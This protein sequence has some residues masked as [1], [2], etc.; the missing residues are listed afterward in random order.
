MPNYTLHVLLTYTYIIIGETTTT[1]TSTLT[2]STTTTTTTAAPLG[3]I[4]YTAGTYAAIAQPVSYIDCEGIPGG[5]SI[6]GVGGYDQETFCAQ[7]GSVSTTGQV[8][9]AQTG[10]CT[11]T[12]TTTA[13][14][15][16]TTTTTVLP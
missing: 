13:S 10:V 16:T 9:V 12:T 11:T 4:E 14:P 8:V 5:F 3:C 1:T 7:E 2:S 15:T 6:G